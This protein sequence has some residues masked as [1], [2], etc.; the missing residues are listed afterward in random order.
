MQGTAANGGSPI[1]P[2]PQHELSHTD[3]RR[4]EDANFLPQGLHALL[5]ALLII[6]IED[7]AG[8]AP[9]PDRPWNQLSGQDLQLSATKGTEDN[10]FHFHVWFSISSS[11]SLFRADANPTS[12]HPSA[13][14]GSELR[15]T[16]TL[17]RQHHCL[18]C[19][20]TNG[21]KRCSQHTHGQ[22]RLDGFKP[23][24]HHFTWQEAECCE[25]AQGM[26]PHQ[27]GSPA[28]PPGTAQPPAPGAAP[29]VTAPQA[30]VWPRQAGL[31]EIFSDA[32]AK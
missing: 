21:A 4:G 12:L 18:P 17:I 1:P 30:W 27:D 24:H 20:E 31:L 6:D 32:T 14:P 28:L 3:S 29:L 23:F 9:A 5:P 16:W 22:P 8:V 19:V 25:Q 26:V 7:T 11:K 10:G 2:P 13:N 15:L